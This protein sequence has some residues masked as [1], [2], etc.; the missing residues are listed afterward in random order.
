MP[1]KNDQAA[2]RTARLGNEIYHRVVA[3][4]LS[5]ADKGRVVAIDVNS[6]SWTIGKNGILAASELRG[7]KP[8][9]DVWLVRVGSKAYHRL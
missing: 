7:V 2:E 3:G 8:E 9:A 1:I 6:E 5:S 4:Q